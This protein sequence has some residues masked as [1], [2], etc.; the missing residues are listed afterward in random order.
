MFGLED[1]KRGKKK[2]FR[3][4]IEND[5]QDPEKKKQLLEKIQDRLQQVKAKLRE[6]EEDQ[7]KYDQLGT[8]LY[9]Y[10]ALMQVAKKVGSNK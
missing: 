9:G 6:G 8:L 2:D 5:M 10:V 4:D 3:Y 1:D 7:T